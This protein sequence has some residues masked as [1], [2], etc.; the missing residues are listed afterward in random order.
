MGNLF[1]FK[2]SEFRQEISGE[3]PEELTES[4]TMMLDACGEIARELRLTLPELVEM[5]TN[6]YAAAHDKEVT[7]FECEEEENGHA[8]V[9]VMADRWRRN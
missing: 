4:L 2:R 9:T 7:H 6:R 8:T 3:D 5:A 1:D